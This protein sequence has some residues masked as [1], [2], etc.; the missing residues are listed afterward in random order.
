M[1]KYICLLLVSLDFS[2]VRDSR[3]YKTRIFGNWI[4]FHP[5]VKGGGEK[6]PAHLGPLERANLNYCVIHHRQNPSE[7]TCVYICDYF[8][9]SK[10]EYLLWWAG[11]ILDVV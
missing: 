1:S 11:G 3:D 2:I 7:S 6:K 4:C 9:I 5:Q 10:F 8:I